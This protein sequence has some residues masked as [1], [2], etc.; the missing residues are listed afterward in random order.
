MGIVKIFKF[1]CC[2][3]ENLTLGEYLER[4]KSKKWRKGETVTLEEFLTESGQWSESNKTKNK[5]AHA[6]NG[7]NT[8]MEFLL[9]DEVVWEHIEAEKL[10]KWEKVTPDWTCEKY[11]V[12]LQ[13]SNNIYMEC[14]NMLVKEY[15]DEVKKCTDFQR[16]EEICERMDHEIWLNEIMVIREVLDRARADLDLDYAWHKSHRE[17]NREMHSSNGNIKS[18]FDHYMKV[19]YGY[20]NVK[21]WYGKISDDFED[22]FRNMSIEMMVELYVNREEQASGKEKDRAEK[23]MDCIIQLLYLGAFDE[24]NSSVNIVIGR[25]SN[26]E[27]SVR[28]LEEILN[29]V[30]KLKVINNFGR[31]KKDTTYL[32]Q[33]PNMYH[34]CK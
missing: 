25:E 33:Q 31:K 5:R 23:M 2:V 7:N 9:R 8:Y 13:D 18:E 26:V 17:M 6:V 11:G 1:W 12:S 32:I 24:C 34:T 22:N 3:S 19:R 14:K 4:E 16:I 29:K 27:E 30:N 21:N 20:K 10:N 28:I 15:Y